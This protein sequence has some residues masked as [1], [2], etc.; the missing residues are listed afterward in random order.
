M[1][2]A[3]L[4]E[5]SAESLEDGERVASPKRRRQGETR[6]VRDSISDRHLSP[7]L[8]ELAP[9]QLQSGFLAGMRAKIYN[10][11]WRPIAEGRIEP[12]V[13][14][15]ERL[16]REQLGVAR[17]LVIS[18]FQQMAAEGILTFPF[19][20]TPY[21][22]KPSPQEARDAFDALD[23]AIIHVIRG[24]SASSRQTF[25]GQS[26]LLGQHLKYTADDPLEVHLLESEL[27]ILLA[28]AHGAT[29]ITELVTRAVVLRTLSLKLYGDFP[30]PPWG[31]ASRCRLVDAIFLN[32][33]DEAVNEFETRQRELRD[34]LKFERGGRRGH[35]DIAELLQ[36][37]SLFV[38]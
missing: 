24:L 38:K 19:N 17:L 33:P 11:L 25:G 12:G 14:L 3:F 27:L 21:V 23:M 5:T 18:V 16:V 35:R 6:R 37:S 7:V 8:R 29:L 10:T 34:S 2:R 15:H 22:A 30:P 36:P 32:R 31:A 4:Q 9:E 1:S 13:K 26:R 28:V 20:K